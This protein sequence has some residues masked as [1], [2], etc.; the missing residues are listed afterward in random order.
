MHLN[1]HTDI[2]VL[3]EIMS[4]INGLFL[5]GGAA[6]LLEPE[7]ST[8]GKNDNKPKNATANATGNV[9]GNGTAMQ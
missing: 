5:T 2:K 4:Q 8:E 3:K 6:N 7:Q 1:F 9:V